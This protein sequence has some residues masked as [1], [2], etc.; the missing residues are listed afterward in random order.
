MAF[1]AIKSVSSP[2]I[3]RTFLTVLYSPHSKDIYYISFPKDNLAS[4]TVVYILWLTET[5]QTV[6]NMIDTFDMFSYNFGNA[7][8]LNVVP[9]LMVYD[10]YSLWIWCVVMHVHLCFE[11]LK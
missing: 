5:V 3:V 6:S 7:S 10:S 8:E 11:L 9:S 4:K 2:I 1:C